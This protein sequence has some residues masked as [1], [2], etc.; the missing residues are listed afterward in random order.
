M[1]KKDIDDFFVQNETKLMQYINVLY[2]CI[3]K[4]VYTDILE[5]TELFDE[6]Y[7]YVVSHHYKFQTLSLTVC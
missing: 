7:L 6:L 3:Y 2:K 1:D 4:Y 5:P